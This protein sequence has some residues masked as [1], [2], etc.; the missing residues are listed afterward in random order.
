MLGATPALPVQACPHLLTGAAMPAVRVGIV[1]WN[2][3]ECLGACLDA[4]PAAL[5]GVD[6]EIV[7]VDNAS[8]DDSAAVGAARPWVRV[9]RNPD[10]IGYARAM[11]QA[12]GG[13]N[14]E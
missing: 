14:A 2:T 5:E 4:L 1:S 6:A 9:V 3:A 12:L 11:N 10:N 8:S 7:L 13:T